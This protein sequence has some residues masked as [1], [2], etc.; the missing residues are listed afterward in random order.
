MGAF[1]IGCKQQLKQLGLIDSV[2]FITNQNINESFSAIINKSDHVKLIARKDAGI[3]F[4]PKL[5]SKKEE[6]SYT[7]LNS[8]VEIKSV[9]G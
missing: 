2:P 6:C 3:V 5:D 7:I 9:K 1:V 4:Q 8:N